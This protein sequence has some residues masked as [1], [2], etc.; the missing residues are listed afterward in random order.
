MSHDF[1]SGWLEG[2]KE[3][4]HTF[5]IFFNAIFLTIAYV[6]GIV[7]TAVIARL[8]GKRFLDMEIRT[9]RPSYWC[10]H[11]VKSEPIKKYERQF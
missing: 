8:V 9:T 2:F 4:G 1:F 5:V 11:V 10:D 6:L 7:I 3:V